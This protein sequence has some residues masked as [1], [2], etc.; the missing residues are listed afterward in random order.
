[1]KVNN[2]LYRLIL[3]S[4]FGVFS[5]YQSA[6]ANDE[7]LK[8]FYHGVAS[9]DPMQNAVVIW[10]RVTPEGEGPV[11]VKWR[12]ATDAYMTQ[13][14]K[15]G[16]LT[17]DVD[18]D[19]TVKIDVTGLDP[20][21]TYYYD[22][23]AMGN[24][25]LVGKTKTAP[26]GMADQLRFAVVSCSNY[27]AGF[28]NAYGRIA[29][30]NDLDAV[31]HLGDY[32]YE[33]SA[34]GDDFYGNESIRDN[35]RAHVPDKELL[36]LDDYRTRYAQYRMDPDL[37]RAHQQHAFIT[38]WDDHESANDAYE[39]GAENHN[40]GE[41]D[42]EDRKAQ[43]KQAYLE[44]FPVRSVDPLYRTKSFGDLMDLIMIDTRLE[45]RDE[46]IFD[47][48][49]PLV[50]AP[51]RTLL[52]DEQRN[53][54]L[55]ELS[56]STARWKIIGNQVIF[57]EFNVGWAAAADP[58]LG[59]PEQ[60]ESIFMDIW[61]GYPAE[62]DR[63]I[64]HII[65]EAI[66]D[67]V[68]LT[69]DFHSAFAY[70]V[71][72]RPSVFSSGGVPTY[73]PETGEG[74]VAVEFA[75]QSVT[76]ANFDEN[77]DPALAAGLELQINN[78]FP[79][80]D[81]AGVNPNPHMKYVDLDRHGYFLL[82]VTPEKV[83][84]D[85]YYVPIL[86]QSDEE[87]F[88][89]GFYSMKGA[90]HLTQAEGPSA[91][92]IVQDDPAPDIP[93][94]TLGMNLI[95][96]YDSGLGEGAAEISAFD[97]ASRRLFV[98]NN[99]AVST[100]QILDL[101][102]PAM[103]TEVGSIDITTYGDGAN[104]VDVYD[105]LVAV[106]VEANP[107][108]DPGKVVFFNTDGDFLAQVTV[109]VLPDMLVFTPDGSKIVVANE[110][111]PNDEYTIDPEGSVSIISIPEDVTTINQSNVMSADFSAFNAADLRAAGVRIFG[112]GATAA[113]DLEPEYI[114]VSEDGTTA[115]VACQENNAVAVVNINTATVNAV[116]PLGFKDHTLPD[117]KLDASN[118]DGGINIQN[119]PVKG[120]YQ[121]DAI[122]SYQVGGKTYLVTAN[123]GDARDYDGF[124]EEF[125][126]KD[127]TLDPAAFP[128]AATL[129]MDENLG[130]LR[131]TDQL[132]FNL[133]NGTKVFNELYSYGARSFSIWDG[134]TGE[135]VFDSGDDL[136][137]ITA[138]IASDIFNNDE[139]EVDERSDDKGP[140]PEG[141]TVG[142]VD[143][144]FYA[145]IGL[146]RTGGV[147]VYDITDPMNP[148]FARYQRSAEGNVSPEGLIFIAADKSPNGKPLLVVAHEVSG[149]VGIYEIDSDAV[150]EPENFQLQILHASDLEGGVDAIDNAPNFAALVD[151]FEEEMSTLV[152]S[153]GD[154]YI[155]GPFF[156]AA[157]NRSLRPVLQEVYQELFNEPALTN[158][159]EGDGRVDISLMNI[160]GF[161][162]SAL[163]NHEFDAGTNTLGDLIGTDIRGTTLGDVRWLGA[164]F[165]YLSANL[166]FSADGNLS[167]LFTDQILMG[168]AFN[169]LPGDLDAAADAPKIAPAAILEVAGEQVGVV[170][171]TTQI[172][173]SITS[174]GDVEVVGP[175]E[176]DMTALADVLQPV[177][178]ELTGQGI[179]KII[180][181]THLQQV[182]LEETLVGLLSG[183]DIVLAGGS[184]V[185]FA[186]EDD[187]LRPEDSP[188]R[189][190]PF[191]TSNS[192]GDPAV[193][194][195][196]DGE[197]SYLGR[198][199]VEFDDMGVLIP[200]SLDN[201]MSGAYATT[202]AVVDEVWETMDPFSE[203]SKGA[204]VK[205]LTDAIEAV[206]L[207]QDGNIVGKTA[208]FLDGRRSQ[209]RTEETNLG[210]LT[211]D[212]NLAAAQMYDPE[213]VGSL[214]NGGGIRAA[215]GQ[216]VEVSPG[217]YEPQPPQANPDAGKQ[218][219]DISQLDITNSLRFN[220][221]LTILSL[222]A[223][224][225]KAV[226]EHAVSATE[227]GATPGQ[228]PQVGGISF[229]Y[230]TT[231]EPGNRILRIALIDDMGDETT[232]V[233][234]NDMFQV[235]ED[236][237]Y[238]IVTLNFLADGGDG[239][240]Y[241]ELGMNRVNLYEMDNLEAGQ[242]D[243]ADAGTEQDAL[244]E[245]LI[246]NYSEEPFMMEETPIEEDNRIQLLSPA[247]L[248]IAEF[249]LINTDN[250]QVLGPINDGDV[251]DFY[252]IGTSNIS[253]QAITD[254]MEVGSVEFLLN[255]ELEQ[256]ENL[257]PYSISGDHSNGRFRPWEAEIIPGTYSVTATPYSES[258]RGGDRG[259]PSTINFEIKDSGL[260]IVRL[261]LVNA[262]TN[263]DI[264]VLEDSSIV[265]YLAIG[266]EMLNIRAETRAGEVGSVAFKL[267][268]ERF[269][270]ESFLP[271][272]IAGDRN[273]DYRL[274]ENE[275]GEYDL[276]VTAYSE[277]RAEGYAGMPLSIDFE[278]VDGAT[279]CFAGSVVSFNQG[280]TKRGSEIMSNRSNPQNALGK[281]QENNALNFVSLGFGGSITLELG[282]EVYDDGT[283]EPEIILVESTYGRADNFCFS[284]GTVYY[285][286][287]AYVEVS[288]DGKQW[289][290]LPNSYC[291]TSFLDINPAVENGM[292]FAKYIRITDSSNQYEFGDNAD[293]F[294]VDGVIICP[295][296]VMLAQ[297]RLTN[298]RLAGGV[299]VFDPAF[300]N[301]APNEPTFFDMEVYPNPVKDQ[302]EI[303]FTSDKKDHLGL[304]IMNTMGQVLLEKEHDI[305]EGT[306][307]IQ[308]NSISLQKGVYL[309]QVEQGDFVE[310]IKFMK[311]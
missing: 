108:T 303:K 120:M 36:V 92:K 20:G 166:D 171:A 273:G 128:D 56:N 306:N 241:P 296:E 155:P 157:G 26:E 150:P 253:I 219:G 302:L 259:L 216:I 121:P 50:Y 81:L 7:E 295:E 1:M 141:V 200:A 195:G 297:E 132:G 23:N 94:P 123:E 62:R 178:D 99:A 168:G 307:V 197:Y 286:E 86:E 187:P 137:Q 143:G 261:V 69:G 291:R 256:V 208:V 309:L 147:M 114:T 77:L 242:S 9:G 205:K 13:V 188:E 59:T 156:G 135:L 247:N 162:A 25:S 304:R 191:V 27:Q 4:I 254:P 145:F 204:L 88:D 270:V 14:V 39:E 55:N 131:V 98:V 175:D 248:F 2:L 223:A 194:V 209:V 214:K 173:E 281:P 311:E 201:P 144:K 6:L 231:Y 185:L 53:W 52:G 287:Q 234:E 72:K 283:A 21:T 37:R 146:E 87:F 48:T 160:I 124:S 202:S 60:V 151:K 152:I 179:N 210:N 80:G 49:N 177:I 112:P 91:E 83:Q 263:E 300:F 142:M 239:Y 266:T 220:N 51:D 243:F 29:D 75:T 288:H 70:D 165:P 106:A 118:E 97:P 117:N 78:P 224:D 74:S 8:P 196:T 158:I 111:E 213:V 230:D 3:L 227:P 46:Q 176:N 31:I 238:K 228:F 133:E 258:R 169:S 289:Y 260:D 211:A 41:G 90:N 61:D 257:L 105:G 139:G 215:I 237:E 100:L 269:S 57:S 103:P 43:A 18:R 138:A 274:W 240:P 84:A 122:A 170:G 199:I 32:I 203:G 236:M 192:D 164:Q 245:Y 262:E 268:G 221:G 85:F 222:S 30:R 198:L 79:S 140:E 159:R 64:D 217:V 154:N 163:G 11:Q 189:G 184:D 73:N 58:S 233:F 115:Y 252:E 153:S 38:V 271:Y 5:L 65:D 305:V 10:T 110:G 183:V 279:V 28:F 246:E 293:G 276:M 182:A 66:D 180:L 172:L 107:S 265:D 292:P 207:A 96:N 34:T 63:I 229:V 264:M 186:Q 116:L 126:V 249:L 251:I 299:T 15:S 102:N 45:G 206:V 125:R 190:Y 22:F 280:K 181:T 35:G 255:G 250:N 95:G 40:P 71:A 244:A 284:N 275:P 19:F 167:G 272:A 218:E 232:V 127:F 212:A 285:P 278:I 149:T 136:E 235:A 129:Q 130:R 82:D 93:A 24:N 76:S 290:S 101:N 113:Q 282:S 109:G 226:L 225:L 119:W 89:A 301:T 267:N 68:I 16:T 12:M 277:S 104:H 148:Q 161:D 33:Y 294:D 17:T 174:N 54:F 67:V 193:I 47:V 310:A 298:A 308:W 44:W 134:A 42:W